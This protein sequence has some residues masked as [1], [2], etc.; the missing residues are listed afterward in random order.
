M[1]ICMCE[2]SFFFP[3]ALRNECPEGFWELL[4]GLMIVGVL[5]RLQ[6]MSESNTGIIV[7]FF[8]GSVLETYL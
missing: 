3:E 2:G 8:K 1:I 7:H 4:R 5:K 6:I